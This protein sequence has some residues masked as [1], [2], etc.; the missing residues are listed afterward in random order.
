VQVQRDDELIDLPAT[1]RRNLE[2]TQ[3]LRGEDSPHAVLAAGHL[4][5]RHGQPPAQ[6]LAAGAPARP[7][8]ARSAWL[9]LPRCAAGGQAHLHLPSPPGQPARQLKGVSDVER[10]TARIAL[11][12][13][14]PR[15]LVAWAKRYK[16]QSCSRR[17]RQAPEPYLDPNFQ[18]FAAATQAAPICCTAP[19]ATRR[20]RRPGARRRRDR[21]RL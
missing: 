13:V 6:K 3:T 7:H 18:P 8:E 16:K 5:D 9:P 15:E 17:L 2:L 11:R 4:H 12:Q 21:Q 19:C 20:T 14:R 10:I 1:T